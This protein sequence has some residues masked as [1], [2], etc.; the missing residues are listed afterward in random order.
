M[1]IYIYIYILYVVCVIIFTYIYTWRWQCTQQVCRFSSGLGHGK[2]LQLGLCLAWWFLRVQINTQGRCI[3][4][5]SMV[6]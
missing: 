2:L 4:N 6:T 1:Y 3:A 5:D